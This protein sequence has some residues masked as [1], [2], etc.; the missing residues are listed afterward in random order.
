ME[1]ELILSMVHKNGDGCVIKCKSKDHYDRLLIRFKKR[2]YKEV[3]YVEEIKVDK[4]PF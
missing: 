4:L 1:N 2:G 3:P